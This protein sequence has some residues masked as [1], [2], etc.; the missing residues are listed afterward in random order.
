M[1]FEKSLI[2]SF[3][4]RYSLTSKIL[5]VD[6]VKYKAVRG[7]YFATFIEGKNFIASG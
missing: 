4:S 3:N 5:E 2:D 6:L 7:E 1:N